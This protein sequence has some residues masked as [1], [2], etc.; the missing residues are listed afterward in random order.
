MSKYLKLFFFW[1]DLS[2]LVAPVTTQA[3]ELE[4]CELSLALVPPPH[5]QAGPHVRV[6]DFLDA[7]HICFLSWP[8][9]TETEFSLSSIDRFRLL[10]EPLR[11]PSVHAAD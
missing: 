7:V 4:T 5:L 6:E 8:V 10:A 11:I 2:S 3:F 1:N 9:L